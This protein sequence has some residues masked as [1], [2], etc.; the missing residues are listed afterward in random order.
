MIIGKL[1]RL[2]IFHPIT[3]ESDKGEM[4][5]DDVLLVLDHVARYM[6]SWNVSIGSLLADRFYQW[7][8]PCETSDHNAC[9]SLATT[10]ALVKKSCSLPLAAVFRNEQPASQRFS[11]GVIIAFAAAA[12]HA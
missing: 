2:K 8:A 1:H 10:K 11:L 7:V 5:P 4:Q 9:V 3:N 12:F 6:R